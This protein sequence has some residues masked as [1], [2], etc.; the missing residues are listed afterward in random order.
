MRGI[1]NTRRRNEHPPAYSFAG[2]LVVLLVRQHLRSRVLLERQRREKEGISPW[3]TGYLFGEDC[4]ST[5][6]RQSIR[7][8]DT[9]LESAARM[10]DSDREMQTV[11]DFKDGSITKIV[12]K[13]FLT[14]HYSVIR[15]GPR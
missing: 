10:T 7:S 1:D 9:S 2:S 4:Q 3:H 12:L 6:Q 8:F 5:K 13:N 14:Y 15:P 11:G